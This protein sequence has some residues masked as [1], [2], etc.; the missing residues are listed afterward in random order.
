[1]SFNIYGDEITYC[2]IPFAT[3]DGKA[4]PTLRAGAT[5]CLL[6]AEAPDT[7][8][9]KLYQAEEQGKKDGYKAGYAEAADKHLE[10]IELALQFCRDTID[11]ME[12]QAKS[13]SEMKAQIEKDKAK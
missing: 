2:G 8:G 11:T 5:D 13:L 10:A 3:I 1:M 4:W 7:F 6:S 9:E 12:Q